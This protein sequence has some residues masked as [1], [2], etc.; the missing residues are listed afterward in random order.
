LIGMYD[1]SPCAPASPVQTQASVHTDGA[2]RRAA[3]NDTRAPKVG[4][5]GATSKDKPAR[6]LDGLPGALYTQS[7]MRTRGYWFFYFTSTGAARWPSG[8]GTVLR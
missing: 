2:S 7:M 1:G 4:V 5:G 6:L 8:S 3:R